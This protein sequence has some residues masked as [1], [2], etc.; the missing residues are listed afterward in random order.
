[1]HITL[2]SLLHLAAAG[3]AAGN[4]AAGNAVPTEVEYLQYYF[5]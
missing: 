2:N 1:M 5:Q 4:A 3:N